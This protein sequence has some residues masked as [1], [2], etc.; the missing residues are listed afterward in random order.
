MENLKEYLANLC[1]TFEKT[2]ST[3]GMEP[4]EGLDA[5]EVRA[6]LFS[7]KSGGEEVCGALIQ[8]LVLDEGESLKTLLEILKAGRFETLRGFIVTLLTACG[9]AKHAETILRLIRRGSFLD[10]ER[11]LNAL[12]ETV[13]TDDKR[14]GNLIS[15]YLLYGD[16]HSR[17]IAIRAVERFKGSAFAETLAYL[18]EKEGSEPVR[19]AAVDAL[20]ALADSRSIPCLQS[21]ATADYYPSVRERAA[22]ALRMMKV[23]GGETMPLT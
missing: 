5:K 20:G 9:T 2:G 16:Q 12:L 7:P 11:L 1:K 10:R 6:V 19:L 15:D 13:G 22:Q 18:L 3:S 17:L 21:A 23:Q 14:V 4:A 8:L